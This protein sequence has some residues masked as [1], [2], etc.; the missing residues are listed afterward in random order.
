MVNSFYSF[1]V[2]PFDHPAQHRA[3]I[4]HTNRL[5]QFC[6][7]TRQIGFKNFIIIGAGGHMR[8]ST[9]RRADIN[10][11]FGGNPREKMFA[12]KIIRFAAGFIF[13]SFRFSAGDVH[14]E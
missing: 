2:S 13:N 7:F 11:C 14:H 10:F 9:G 8:A 6:F 12:K 1:L 4:Q 5:F 3:F